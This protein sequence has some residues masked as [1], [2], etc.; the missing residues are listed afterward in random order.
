MGCLQ[1]RR[2][3]EFRQSCKDILALAFLRMLFLDFWIIQGD[4]LRVGI[5]LLFLVVIKAELNTKAMGNGFNAVIFILDLEAV[6]FDMRCKCTLELHRKLVLV[7]SYQRIVCC[8]TYHPDD[9]AIKLLVVC[10]HLCKASS[11]SRDAFNE[12]AR[13]PSTYSDGE[14]TDVTALRVFGDIVE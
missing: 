4:R 5:L 6:V 9:L 13:N 3:L 11:G 1:K 8:V 12:R 7:P 14:D 2:A 10:D